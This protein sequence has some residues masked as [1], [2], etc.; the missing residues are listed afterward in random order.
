MRLHSELL[1]DQER[2]LGRNHPDTLGSLA[3]LGSR[4]SWMETR[5][6]DVGGYARGSRLP[7]PAR[8]WSSVDAAVSRCDAKA[9]LRRSRAGDAGHTRASMTARADGDAAEVGLGAVGVFAQFVEPDALEPRRGGHFPGEEGAEVRLG[10]NEVLA[11]GDIEPYGRPLRE[12]RRRVEPVVHDRP[13]A[14]RKA[15]RHEQRQRLREQVGAFIDD[16][17]PRE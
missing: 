8:P 15:E 16:N 7:G 14:E 1:P 6:R 17:R 10:G 5:P 12:R 11:V 13:Q 9:R 4:P 3:A 2:V